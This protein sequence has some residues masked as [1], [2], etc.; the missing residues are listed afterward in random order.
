[1][2]STTEPI[3]PVDE[4]IAQ[5]VTGDDPVEAARMSFGDHLEELRTT[6]I[7]AL[8]GVAIATAAALACGNAVL[9]IVFRPLWLVQRANGL[10]PNLQS[11]APSDAFTAYLKMSVMVGLII[12]MPWVLYQVWSFVAA[13]LYSYEKKFAKR[14][15]F[16]ST[17]LFVTGVFFLY[18][19]VLPI[20]LQFF[21]TFNRAFEA[22]AIAPAGIE[23]LLL[24]TLD[25]PKTSAESDS[26]TQIP[27]FTGDPK[28]AKPGDAWI[29]PATSRLIIKREK[30]H[31][32]VPLEP[33]A[34]AP[35]VDSQFAVP[36]YI[37]FVLMLAL[38]FGI[39]FETPIVVC[40]L[41]W[42]GLVTTAAMSRGRRHVILAMVILAAILTPPDVVSQILLALPM[43]CL[44]EGGLRVARVIERR[45]AAE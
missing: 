17:G 21:I 5:K 8:I 13:G 10:Q 3:E 32:S 41:A 11:L 23:R 27:V 14:L 34:V 38:A 18:F 30:G 36:A 35:A 24:G 43:Y 45:K 25:E 29:D 39:A 40:F 44:F 37:S 33:G 9:E 28:S 22:G 2:T 31:W 1:M 16:A 15:T 4:P 19:I 42:S 26:F 12:S 6:L 20:V 7:R